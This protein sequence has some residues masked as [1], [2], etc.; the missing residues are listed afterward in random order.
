MA[1]SMG[2]DSPRDQALDRV[3][4]ET[5]SPSR[6]GTAMERAFGLRIARDGSWWHEGRPIGRLA[7]VKLFAS[8]LRRAPDGSHWLVTPVER[9]RIEVEDVA[10]VAVEL[11]VEGAGAGARQQL[12][13]RTNLDQWVTVGPDHPL[14]VRRSVAPAGE[15]ALVPYVEVQGGLEARLARPV[16]YELVELGEDQ[17]R[18]GR[19]RFGVWSSGVFFPL[20]EAG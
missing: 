11:A 18:D 16:Y 2:T 19:T 5:L 4:G 12:R 10:F 3:E 8:V 17:C 6:A 13:L 20:D 7:L 15:A 9:G 1:L 14:R